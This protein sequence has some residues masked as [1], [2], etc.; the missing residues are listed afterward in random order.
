MG[1]ENVTEVLQSFSHFIAKS[2]NLQQKMEEEENSF[3]QQP[4]LTVA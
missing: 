3:F 2:V 1:R 4:P